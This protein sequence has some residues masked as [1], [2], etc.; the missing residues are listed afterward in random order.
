MEARLSDGEGD[1]VDKIRWNRDRE[2][3]VSN[4]IKATKDLPAQ[5]NGRKSIELR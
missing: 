4:L 3:V 1:G 5:G 2:S